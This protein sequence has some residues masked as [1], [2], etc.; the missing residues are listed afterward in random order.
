MRRPAQ[1]EFTSGLPVR[2]LGALMPTLAPLLD[3]T[4][5]ML[6][7]AANASP[8]T[9]PLSVEARLRRRARLHPGH[10]LRLSRA[11]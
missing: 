10:C 3:G 7:L 2:L 9:P 8:A 5:S 1:Y 11:A 4:P 6:A